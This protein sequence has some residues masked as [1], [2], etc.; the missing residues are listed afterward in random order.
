M[1]YGLWLKE[2][3][4]EGWAE[5]AKPVQA[6][7]LLYHSTLGLI[8][9]KKKKKVTPVGVPSG[10]RRRAR[11]IL[12]RRHSR[13][14]LFFFITLQPR[15]EWYTSLWA[16]NTSPPR[17]RFPFLRSSC[18]EIEIYT[19]RYS[20]QFKSWAGGT[21]PVGVPSGVRRRARNILI[22]RHT[23]PRSLALYTLRLGV[24]VPAELDFV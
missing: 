22:R 1:V 11:N 5:G 2:T 4:R 23:P 12:I 21:T 10:V 3:R 14:L 16:L 20:S 17:N 6:H 24:G 9:I 13:Y 19:D 8:V 15:V 7:R 18:S